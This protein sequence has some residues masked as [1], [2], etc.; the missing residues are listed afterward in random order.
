MAKFSYSGEPIIYYRLIN[1]NIFGEQFMRLIKLTILVLLI[2]SGNIVSQENKKE[3]TAVRIS[4]SPIID[5]K[6]DE[7]IW[8]NLPVLTDFIKYFPYNGTPCSQRSEAKVCYDDEA[9]YVGAVLYDNFPDSMRT[10][11]GTRDA[12]DEQDAELISVHISPFDDGIN[13]FYF[14]VS[15]RGVQS[16]MK[17]SAE[18]FQMAWDA[19]WESETSIADYGWIAEIKIPFSALRF[20]T[21]QVQDWG[22]NI[23]RYLPRYGE[24]ANWSYISNEL[25][26]WWK[27]RGVL[28]GIR[29]V[30]PPLRLSF[31][32][33]VSTYV[34]KNTDNEWGYSFNGGM[35]LKFGID[36]SFTLDATVIPDFGQVQSD[37][38]VLNL[39]PYEIQY[40]EKR[41][42]FTEGTELFNKG[43]IFYSRRIGNTPVD[44]YAISGQLDT[45]EVITEN[46]IET[47]LINSTKVSGRTTGGLGIGVMNSMTSN[48][49]AEIKDT[50]TGVEREIQ[51]QPFTNY[52]IFV[53]DQTLS[54]N[55][56]ISL[57]NTNV[58][59]KEYVA[60]V[61]A[62]DFRLNDSDNM[63][64]LG[65]IGALSQ[66][67]NS[68]NSD[69]GYK[70]ELNTGKIGGEFRCRY[71]FYLVSDKYNPNDLGY[72]YR[73]NILENNF[74]LG[75]HLYKP[76]G[77]FLE[78]HNNISLNYTRLF[79]PGKFMEF[80][81]SYEASATLENRYNVNMHA[82]IVPM[83][84]NDYHE[85]R[86]PGRVFNL[87]R[88]FHNC[89]HISSDTRKSI[90]FFLGGGISKSYSSDYDW[91]SYNL[92]FEPT[93]RVNNQLS[94]SFETFFSKSINDLGYVNK[95]TENDIIRFG[96]R[97]RSIFENTIEANYILSNRAS[98]NFRLRHYWSKVDYDTFYDL[99]EDGN[100]QI[101]N[102]DGNHDINYNAFNIDLTFKWN[103]APGSELN[104]VWKNIIYNEDDD[105][106]ISY[107]NNLT[108]TFSSPQVNSLSLKLLYYIDGSKLF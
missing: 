85:A 8:K 35:D 55:S 32:P 94:F 101:N 36:E 49:Y 9:L 67:H 84:R 69:Y 75:H 47:R 46:P 15:I 18:G 41:Q 29:D 60:N 6:L 98:L 70:L 22:F 10:E 71:W 62:L 52:N 58:L 83:E 106:N 53:L 99:Q 61:S 79:N 31:S 14:N 12:V 33:Y 95:D 89:L 104:L 34:E 73:N 16:D 92:S 51:T 68:G 57:V 108:N 107:W 96:K 90:W 80:Y 11:L 26:Q 23:F 42:F 39:S 27:H 25:D 64:K 65:G 20:S 77:I 1:K 86:T 28:K 4:T 21:E 3:T 105:V 87:P 50:V 97:D 40:N 24:W 74:I 2:V 37:D 54:N 17:I 78:L 38:V 91:L 93:L 45:N 56:Y 43:G 82:M 63:Y 48:T 5:G 72:L 76:F 88:F 59:R 13:A 100:L 7:E 102:Y 103:F 19:V 30:N 81:I 44:H 66:I